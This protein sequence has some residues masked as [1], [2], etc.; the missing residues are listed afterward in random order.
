MST[1]APE[2]QQTANQVIEQAGSNQ[3]EVP[4]G[5]KLT[6]MVFA[7]LASQGIYVSAKLGIA[8]L[9]AD[10]PKTVTE[11]AQAAGADADALYRIL[12]ALSSRGV[13][14]EREGRVFEQSP[15]SDLLRANVTGSLRDAVIFM[16]EDWHWEVL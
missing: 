4:A 10:G 16:G 12:R 9:L 7:S 5:F 8:D 15:M 2:V 13:F 3:T 11:L 1:A 14:V 6:E